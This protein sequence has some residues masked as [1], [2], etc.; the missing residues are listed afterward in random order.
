MFKRVLVFKEALVSKSP[1]VFKN[2]FEIQNGFS[3]QTSE[4]YLTVLLVKEL[5]AVACCRRKVWTDDAVCFDREP[6]ARLVSLVKPEPL[7]SR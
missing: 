7:E 3:V 4:R 1:F 5:G 2:S 6:L